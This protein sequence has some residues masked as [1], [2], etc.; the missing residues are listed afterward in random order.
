[1][2]VEAAEVKEGKTSPPK[3]FTEDTLLSAMETAGADETPY[4][5]ERKGLGTPATRAATIEKLVQRG[6]KNIIFAQQ[7]ER[8]R[9]ERYVF[10]FVMICG[11]ALRKE[12]SVCR[13]P[14]AA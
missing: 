7:L 3:H 2:K 12:G 14:E 4:E 10:A 9:M 1:V 13:I 8:E 5:A 11:A 6:F